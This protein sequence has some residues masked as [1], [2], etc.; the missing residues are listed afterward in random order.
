MRRSCKLTDWHT[1]PSGSGE[2]PNSY[3]PKFMVGYINILFIFFS[4][5]TFCILVLKCSLAEDWN[6]SINS[7]K[8][9]I[10]KPKIRL[11]LF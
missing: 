7:T 2:A 3:N 8:P 10:P 4:L 1:L 6:L 5:I 9:V 11:D